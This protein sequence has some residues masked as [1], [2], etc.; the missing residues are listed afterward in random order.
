V[1]FFWLLPK[2]SEASAISALV[3]RWPYV[4]I[5]LSPF[6][7]AS[8]GRLRFREQDRFDRWI[9]NRLAGELSYG[10]R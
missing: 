9:N 7:A 8:L 4:L 3:W 6:P 10:A 1:R 5:P 2:T